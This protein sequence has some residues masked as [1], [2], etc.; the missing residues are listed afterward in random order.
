MIFMKR[1][2][3][4]PV[5]V[6]GGG[7]AGLMAALS[8]AETGAGVLLIER[9]EKVGRKLYITGKGRCNLTNHCTVP[10]L[11][12]HVVRNGKFLYSALTQFPPE[13][14]MA[15]FENLGVALK[16]ERGG[17]VFPV[18]DRA[19]DVVDALYHALPRAGVRL[20][21][22]RVR[23]VCLRDGAVCALRGEAGTY[24]CRAAILATGGAS[25]PA[26][27]STGDGYE[28]A[29]VLGHT[30]LPPKPSLTGLEIEGGECA[31]MQGL[32]LKNV[33]L[34][35]KN[36]AGK[37]LWRE[38]GELL[39]THFGLSG[40][41]IL[42]ASAYMRQFEKESYTLSIDLKPALTPEM[43][44][45]RILR[46]FAAAPNRS[47]ARSLDKLLPSGMIPV[48]VA[49][50]GIEPDRQANAV[51]RGQRQELVRLLKNLVFSVT[52]PRPLEEAVVTA[53]G[54]KVGEVDPSTM[55]SRKVPGL[56]FA[57]E[58]LDVDACTGGYNLQIAWSTGRLAGLSAGR[59]VQEI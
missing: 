50:S 48:I 52:D 49:R 39:F 36:R 43:L 47:F 2:N 3:T 31:A 14:V 45:A 17:R 16:T 8:A 21:R 27:G 20:V 9:N 53:G 11:L 37:K 41:L 15:Y 32:A 35:V 44:D 13:A 23:E 1:T 6:V 12:E 54:V 29:A 10:E 51:T 42:T 28:M 56:Y 40:P 30:L 19:A 18:S 5:A 58:L 22:D 33:A 59:E 4:E 46:D 24:P 38:Q 25:Y 57:G 34:T 7:A 55:A 26:T